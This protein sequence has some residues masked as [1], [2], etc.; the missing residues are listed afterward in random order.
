MLRVSVSCSSCPGASR[1]R[2]CRVNRCCSILRAV[3][4][5][6][7]QLHKTLKMV[8]KD[9]LESH[10]EPLDVDLLTNN[11]EG[12]GDIAIFSVKCYSRLALHRNCISE[13]CGAM[14]RGSGDKDR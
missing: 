12:G 6:D 13:S 14:Q 10:R 4:P 9:T 1:G 11:A 8:L 5:Y 3:W 7:I 2:G